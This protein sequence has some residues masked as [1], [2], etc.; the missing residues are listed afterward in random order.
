MKLPSLAAVPWDMCVILSITL[1]GFGF[2]ANRLMQE[3]RISDAVLSM[4][5]ASP[6]NVVVG[7]VLDIGCVETRSNA[8]VSTGQTYVRVRGKLCTLTRKQLKSF[9]GLNLKNLSTDSE[10]T[11]FFH[12]SQGSFVTD[13]VGLQAGKNLIQLDWKEPSGQHK[14][15]VTEVYGQN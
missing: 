1:G 9:T 2:S 11:V 13:V 8:R 12:G 4:D 10:S 3:H 6:A 15:L 14:T 7:G 5:E